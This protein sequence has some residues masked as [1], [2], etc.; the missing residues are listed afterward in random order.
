MTSIPITAAIPIMLV[1]YICVFVY[2]LQ[3]KWH[4]SSKEDFAFLV[5]SEP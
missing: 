3:V 2:A 4:K 5:P 1:V